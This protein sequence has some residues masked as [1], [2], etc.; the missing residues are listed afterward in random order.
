MEGQPRRPATPL[1]KASLEGTIAMPQVGLGI[2][3]R[4]AEHCLSSEDPKR[5]VAEL[6]APIPLDER[7]SE[8]TKKANAQHAHHNIGRTLTDEE[9]RKVQTA[10]NLQTLKLIGETLGHYFNSRQL[11]TFDVDGTWA[12]P[13]L[14]TYVSAIQK[15]LGEEHLASMKKVFAVTAEVLADPEVVKSLKERK[16][17]YRGWADMDPTKKRQ[18][19]S[20]G[21]STV[22]EVQRLIIDKLYQAKSEVLSPEEDEMFKRIIF[23]LTSAT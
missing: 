9:V 23:Q 18:V 4:T 5:A 22:D 14:E 10:G 12:D 3:L 11:I 16:E 1:E 15:D 13:E 8:R 7:L 20:D 2:R 19:R 21:L 6:I 17:A